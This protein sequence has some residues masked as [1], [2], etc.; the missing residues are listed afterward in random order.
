MLQHHKYLVRIFA[1]PATIL[2][3]TAAISQNVGIGIT[4]PTQ[5]LHLYQPPG[6]SVSNVLYLQ[7]ASDF[8]RNVIRMQNSVGNPFNITKFA[9]NEGVSIGGIEMGGGASVINDDNGP[10]L[11]SNSNFAKSIYLAANGMVNLTVDGATGGLFVRPSKTYHFTAGAETDF[12]IRRDTL[13]ELQSWLEMRDSSNYGNLAG[14]MSTNAGFD[15][16]GPRIQFGNNSAQTSKLTFWTNSVSLRMLIHENGNVGIGMPNFDNPAAKLYVNGTFKMTDGTQGAGKVLTSNV[17]GLASW[18]S[19]TGTHDHFGETWTG[20][21]AFSGLGIINS[22]TTSGSAAAIRGNANGGGSNTARGVEGNS[23]STNGIGIFGSATATGSIAGAFGNSGVAGTADNGNGIF[24]ASLSGPSVYGFKSVVGTNSVARFQNSNLSNTSPV[25]LIQNSATN[26]T[27]LEL[28]N[29][30]IKV[31]GTNKTAFT[32]TATALNTSGNNTAIDYA[33][34]SPT[35][36]IIVTHNWQGSYMGSIGVYFTIG[37][38][39]LFRE[40]L[41]AMPVGEKFNVLVIKQ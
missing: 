14:F 5:R 21:T 22:N 10:L 37:T 18:Q 20:N 19:L 29:G 41:S 6:S 11:I 13:N 15:G 23:N 39:R 16:Y 12:G 9:L 24:G 30:F 4:A 2:F 3:Y 32:V 31:S 35:D 1:I 26:P 33:D 17:A 25:V 7:N 40:D 36:V 28:N 34:P 38:W 8:G 27:A